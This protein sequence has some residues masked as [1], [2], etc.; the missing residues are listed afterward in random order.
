MNNDYYNLLN[1][2]CND[3]NVQFSDKIY[4]DFMMYMELLKEWNKKINIT[5]IDDDEN[6]I[7]KH[8][9]DSIKI[10]KFAPLMNCKKIIDIG[11][12]GGFPG[13]PMKIINPDIDVTLLDS[14]NKR[15]VFLNDVIENLKL[16]DCICVHERAEEYINK[17]EL[18]ETFDAA[19]SR[20]VAYLPA[21]AEYCIPYVKVGGYFLAL[22]GPSFEQEVK[23][24]KDCIKLLGAKIEDI[25]DVNI[26]D[27]SFHHNIV[28]IKKIKQTSRKYPRRGTAIAKT[29]IL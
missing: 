27:S 3:I 7:K 20:A 21:L 12:G 18:R 22:K 6:I 9:I 4:D 16:T 1:C 28:V 26:E 5:A 2:A 24:S 13:L 25:I 19:V 8:F 23:E 14:L 17:F 11:T 10:Y 29:P 15:I